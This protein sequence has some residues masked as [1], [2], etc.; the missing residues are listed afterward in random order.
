[1]FVY[2]KNNEKKEELKKYAG[3]LVA[4]S[5]DNTLEVYERNE[6]VPANKENTCIHCGSISNSFIEDFREVPEIP[7]ESSGLVKYHS[8]PGCY[9]LTDESFW[10]NDLKKEHESFM[11]DCL[12]IVK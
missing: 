1:M 6:V 11:K 12:E 9:A 5:K 3:K 7:K 8:C 2:L 4:K 10:S